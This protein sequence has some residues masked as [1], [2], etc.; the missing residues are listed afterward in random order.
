MR[1]VAFRQSPCSDQSDSC[2]PC[3]V[4]SEKANLAATEPPSRIPDVIASSPLFWIPGG[5]RGRAQWEVLLIGGG[6]PLR[7][8]GKEGLAGYVIQISQW[9]LA[10]VAASWLGILSCLLQAIL[11]TPQMAT[12]LRFLPRNC[13]GASYAG[14][15]GPHEADQLG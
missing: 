4:L 13:M 12:E 6:I 2:P 5:L 11:A 10:G 3:P 9:S 1:M 7:N 15:R 8:G 14:L